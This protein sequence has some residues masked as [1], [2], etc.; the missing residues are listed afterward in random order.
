MSMYLKQPST[1]PQHK[2]IGAYHTL[3]HRLAIETGRWT[4]IPISIQTGLCH[5][6]S[7]NAIENEAHLVL[8]CP[9]YNPI[10][11]KFPSLFENV[12]PRNL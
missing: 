6:C 5:F 9:L 7:Y 10:R 4:I 11:D 1:P 2:I 12:V 8:E 3:N